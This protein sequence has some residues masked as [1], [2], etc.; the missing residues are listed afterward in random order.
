MLNLILMSHVLNT[1]VQHFKI[2]AKV[3]SSL[4]TPWR[5]RGEVQ[6]RYTSTHSSPRH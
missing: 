6:D 2:Q 3:K 1:S 5:H 4:S